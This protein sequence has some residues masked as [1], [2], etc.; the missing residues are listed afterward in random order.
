MAIAQN[1]AHRRTTVL[2]IGADAAKLDLTQLPVEN[3]EISVVSACDRP[4]NLQTVVE[5]SQP[6]LILL[7]ITFADLCGV[8]ICRSLKL[9]RVPGRGVA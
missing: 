9:D 4:E 2:V 7:D 3:I 8:Q 6:H 5:T 1:I